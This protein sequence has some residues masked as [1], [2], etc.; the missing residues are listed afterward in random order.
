VR[1]IARGLGAVV[2]SWPLVETESRWQPDLDALEALVSPATRV[3]A[4]CNPNNPTGARLTSLEL[5]RIC[6]I[7]A[8]RDA[9]VL[10]DEIYRGA[11]LDGI[12]TATIWG[13]YE[14]CVV[15]SGLSKAYGLPGLR[16]G[17]VV[18]QPALV[19]ELWGIHDYTT[20]APG[21]VNDRLARIALEPSRRDLILARTRGIVAANY[22]ILRRWIEA[23]GAKLSHVAPAAGAIA[24]VRYTYDVNSTVLVERLRDEKSVLLVPGDHFDLDRYLRIGFGNHPAHLS[25]ALDLVAEVL[26]GL[27]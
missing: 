19:E 24:F 4:I 13:R 22:T 1:G 26:D 10:S 27:E 8:R 5:D 7:A 25:S 20:I 18:A 15:T 9:W 11:E 21:A 16:I 23:R 17:W 2:H 6:A 14:R 3:I 12:E